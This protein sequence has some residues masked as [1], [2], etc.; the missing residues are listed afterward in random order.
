MLPLPFH[1]PLVLDQVLLLHR[2]AGLAQRLEDQELLRHPALGRRHRQ[3]LVDV[4]GDLDAQACKRRLGV[5][6][7]VRALLA[8]MPFHGVVRHGLANRLEVRAPR[9]DVEFRQVAHAAFSRVSRRSNSS[10]VIAATFAVADDRGSVW[11]GVLPVRW[12]VRKAARSI[13]LDWKMASPLPSTV[14]RTCLAVVDSNPGST[15]VQIRDRAIG[16]RASSW[17]SSTCAAVFTASRTSGRLAWHGIRTKLERCKAF[18]LSREVSPAKSTMTTS[19][20]ASASRRAGRKLWS[21][22]SGTTRKRSIAHFSPKAEA[23]WLMS[24][25]RTYTR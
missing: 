22:M 11:R 21:L 24:Q 6:Q 15:R 20:S 16:T 2:V 17:A 5:A 18:R 7:P 10:L 9:L 1:P 14:L 12:I 8:G 19:A 4:F 25:S 13:R 23:C 3:K